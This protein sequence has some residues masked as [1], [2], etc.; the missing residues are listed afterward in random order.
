MS[1]TLLRISCFGNKNKKKTCFLIHCFI[2]IQIL[3]RFFLYFVS[4][5]NIFYQFIEMEF[6]PWSGLPN[7][8]TNKHKD[9]TVTFQQNLMYYK[10]ALNY[11]QPSGPYIFRPEGNTAHSFRSNASDVTIFRVSDKS[12]LLFMVGCL[13]FMAYQP[14]VLFN[15]KSCLYIYT[16]CKWF[17]KKIVLN[18]PE[19]FVCTQLN[20]FKYCYQAVIVLFA[21]I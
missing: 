18:E 12:L 1:D 16:K 20:D 9:I 19:H 14:F 10:S 8:L 5:V 6:N 2:N 21:H 15:A 3:R 4:Y 17:V 11:D 13:C 7:R